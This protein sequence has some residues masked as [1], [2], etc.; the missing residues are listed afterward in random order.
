MLP[1]QGSRTL[2]GIAVSVS[3]RS[4]AHKRGWKKLVSV[5][6]TGEAHF[7]RCGAA[8]MKNPKLD[9]KNDTRPS[10]KLDFIHIRRHN[11]RY[12]LSAPR[13]SAGFLPSQS[14]SPTASFEV[15]N[16]RMVTV[17]ANEVMDFFS[18][19]I[20]DEGLLE[21][22]HDLLHVII[23]GFFRTV[24]INEIFKNVAGKLV[25]AGIDR[26]RFVHHFARE[27]FFELE[28]HAIPSPCNR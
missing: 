2:T 21:A 14:R 15:G 20:V 3:R 27:D 6:P 5:K 19:S 10:A 7:E 1:I 8:V 16:E 4:Q 26:V 17:L 28:V 25:H 24:V 12:W 9:K 11:K 22:S 13:G 18:L 23:E